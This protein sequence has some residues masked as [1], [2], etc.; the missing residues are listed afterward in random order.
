MSATTAL[1][2]KRN[3][4]PQGRCA[5]PAQ[6]NSTGSRT[7]AQTWKERQAQRAAKRRRSTD[8][9]AADVGA[10][11]DHVAALHPHHCHHDLRQFLLP[12][13]R[14]HPA[15]VTHTPPPPLSHYAHSQWCPSM[16]AK[17]SHSVGRTHHLPPCTA[18]EMYT[19]CSF[20][21]T[22][23]NTGVGKNAVLGQVTLTPLLRTSSTVTTAPL[24]AQCK[25]AEA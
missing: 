11:V 4:R 8:A 21:Y 1:L 5:Q 25:A 18:A 2:L 17:S 3:T 19:S 9:D 12:P 23:M 14:H 13:V 16:P 15:R 10:H 6:A 22:H 20:G 7:R 24:Q